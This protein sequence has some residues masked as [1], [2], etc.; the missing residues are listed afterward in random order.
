MRQTANYTDQGSLLVNSSRINTAATITSG[1]SPCIFMLKPGSTS[2]SRIICN[3]GL[4]TVN[5]LADANGK[6]MQ[7]SWTMTAILS[8]FTSDVD[9]TRKVRNELLGN[10]A[11]GD[12]AVSYDRVDTFTVEVRVR[13]L[14][15]QPVSV[16]L[17]ENIKPY[18]KF[19][20]VT[21]GDSHSQSGNLINLFKCG[22]CSPFRKNN[23][24][25][26]CHPECQ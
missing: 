10:M 22:G 23:N 5:G 21:S 18:F 14:S 19:L 25:P 11:T 20:D 6:S 8:A 4:P 15:G 9:V 13:N 3:T 1:G 2:G 7:I 17:E 12:N 24:L 16:L 26:G